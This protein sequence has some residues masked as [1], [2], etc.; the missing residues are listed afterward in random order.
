MGILI[1]E[2]ILKFI[3]GNFF[4]LSLWKLDGII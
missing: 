4:S 1:Y 3:K 2:E